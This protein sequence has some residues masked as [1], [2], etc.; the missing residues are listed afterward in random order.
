MVKLIRDYQLGVARTVI[1]QQPESK[2]KPPPEPIVERNVQ[3]YDEGFSQG[4]EA[5]RQAALTEHE[6][7]LSDQRLTLKETFLQHIAQLSENAQ[8]I[9]NQSKADAVDMLAAIL[10]QFFIESAMQKEN[11]EHAITK[12][13]HEIQ[14]QKQL[15]LMISQEDF[16]F[17][18]KNMIDLDLPET[19]SIQASAKVQLGGCL[20]ESPDGRLDGRLETQIDKLKSVLL[21]Y[22]QKVAH[23]PS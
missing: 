14:E 17:L 7:Q 6:K 23:E 18:Q 19:I 15:T 11:I 5:G 3:A 16:Q 22:K 21:A 10:P 9:T 13:L 20:V 2:V 1:E 4:Y 12:V 8:K